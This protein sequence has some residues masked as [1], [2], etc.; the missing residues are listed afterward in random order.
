MSFES[1]DVIGRD[2]IIYNLSLWQSQHVEENI[3]GADIIQCHTH[4][5]LPNRV[6]NIAVLEYPEEFVIRCDFMKM[7][8]LLIGK[9]EIW[10]PYGV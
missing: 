8:S 3:C 5:L 4:P 7:G 2:P 1:I 9:E 10:F 6:K